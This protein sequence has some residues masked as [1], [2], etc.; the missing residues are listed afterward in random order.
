VT[1]TTTD[2]GTWFA[3]CMCDDGAHEYPDRDAWHDAI[4]RAR[5]DAVY[6]PATQPHHIVKKESTVKEVTA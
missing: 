2:T 3:L 1:T 5:G 6:Y 4:E